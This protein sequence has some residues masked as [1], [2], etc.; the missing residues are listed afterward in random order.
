MSTQ[1]KVGP[2]LAISGWVLQLSHY[3]V[4]LPFP[5]QF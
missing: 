1:K 5:F 3:G 4:P 2:P